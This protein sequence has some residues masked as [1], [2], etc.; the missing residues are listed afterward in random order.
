MSAFLGRSHRI[1]QCD[2]MLISYLG[3]DFQNRERVIAAR[4]HDDFVEALPRGGQT[5]GKE[6]TS[7]LSP[8][9]AKACSFSSTTSASLRS[10]S[11]CRMGL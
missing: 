5:L 3:I 6:F 9:M 11:A 8:D 2:L 10:N 4:L 7:T 1:G